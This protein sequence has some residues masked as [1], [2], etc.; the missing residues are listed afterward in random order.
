MKPRLFFSFRSPFS[1]MAVERLRRAMPGVHDTFEF[2]PFWEPDAATAAAL[3]ARGAAFHYVTMSKAK[4]LYI[5]HD[6]KRLAQGLGLPVVWPV[7]A[8]PW[9]EPSHLGWLQARRLGRAGAFYEA[10]VS[11]RWH[12]GQNISD[13]HVVRAAAVEAGVDPA[14][15]AGA[16]DDPEIREEGTAC[17]ALAYHDDIF[18]VPFFRVGRERFWGIDRVDALLQAIGMPSAAPRIDWLAGIS[19]GAR[20]AVG[21]YDMDAAGGC[22]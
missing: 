4:H 16:V 13:P 18:G 11:A 1:W 2:V 15:I 14:V 19:A 17:L 20:E 8:T 10:L 7:D 5:L 3:T 21:A 12:R 9:W 6:V 22:G